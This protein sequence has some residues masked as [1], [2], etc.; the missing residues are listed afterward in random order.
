MAN[1]SPRWFFKEVVSIAKK[2][3]SL[4]DKSVLDMDQEYASDNRLSGD[5]Y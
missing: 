3:N 4:A 2:K 5:V 1:D